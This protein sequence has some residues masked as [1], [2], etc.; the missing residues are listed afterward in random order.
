MTRTRVFL[1]TGLLLLVWSARPLFLMAREVVIGTQVARHYAWVPS[2]VSNIDTGLQLTLGS[3]QVELRDDTPP[4]SDHSLSVDG[5][6]QVLIDGHE[7]SPFGNGRIRPAFDTPN[8]YHGSAFLARLT[9]KAVGREYLVVAQSSRAGYRIL[10]VDSDG[11]AT[12]DR[13]G[14][15]EVCAVPVRAMIVRFVTSHPIGYCSDIMQSWP[16]LLF[17]ILYPWTA[18]V[19]GLVLTVCGGVGVWRRHSRADQK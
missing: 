10:W 12:E 19:M 4:T 18:G 9:N 3:H 8:R 16:S 13:F 15:D 14:Y 5:A 7:Y 17:P 6:I 2:A 11:R 1:F